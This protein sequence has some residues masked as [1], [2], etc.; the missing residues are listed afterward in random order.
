MADPEVD[1]NTSNS[2]PS[3]V[4]GDK[5][6]AGRELMTVVIS[7]T[8]LVLSAYFLVITF[9]HGRG[10][11]A[12]NSAS[13]AAFTRMKDILAL[14]LGLLATVTGYYLGRVPAELRASGA[15]KAA[16]VATKNQNDAVKEKEKVKAD[17][18]D[19]VSRALDLMPTGARAR[20][21]GDG[22]APAPDLAE[23]QRALENLRARLS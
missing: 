20:S 14:S 11:F 13:A 16:E 7:L 6:Q 12:E 21:L 10:A 19:T 3:S 9:L 5:A 15:Q 18:K 2:N 17:V 4:S 1:A 23:A 22:T 8:I